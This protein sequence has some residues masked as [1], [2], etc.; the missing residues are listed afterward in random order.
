MKDPPGCMKNDVDGKY[1]FKSPSARQFAAINQHN[2][3]AQLS[4]QNKGNNSSIVLQLLLS[5]LRHCENPSSRL[6]LCGGTYKQIG[7]CM[8]VVGMKLRLG[9]RPPGYRCPLSMYRYI[10]IGCT[11]C[12]LTFGFKS[13]ANI[14]IFHSLFIFKKTLE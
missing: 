12:L 7:I 8:Y 4:T 11:Y 2:P 6:E 1:K 14:I 5:Q 3:L 9:Q 10:L 13:S